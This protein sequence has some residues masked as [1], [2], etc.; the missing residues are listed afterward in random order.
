M[1]EKRVTKKKKEM[2]LVEETIQKDNE[3]EIDG[4]LYILEERDRRKERE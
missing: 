1:K 3:K 4:I 2:C